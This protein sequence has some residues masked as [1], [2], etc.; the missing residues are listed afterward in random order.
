MTI[1]WSLT[2]HL[3]IVYYFLL[4]VIN[5]FNKSEIRGFFVTGCNMSVYKIQ[6]HE[7]Y[8][9]IFMYRWDSNLYVEP[10]GLS[11][12]FNKYFMWWRLKPRGI[13]CF[14]LCENFKSGKHFTIFLKL[15]CAL[16]Y[17]LIYKYILYQLLY[18]STKLNIKLFDMLHILAVLLF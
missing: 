15:K 18:S 12:V 13:N 8:F 6:P 2:G 1:D 5:I 3:A 9:Y 17:L 16:F 7:I 10:Y 14:F 4:C 11:I